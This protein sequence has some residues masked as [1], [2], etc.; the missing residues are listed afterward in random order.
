VKSVPHNKK[1]KSYLF[2][3]IVTALFLSMVCVMLASPTVQFAILSL[4]QDAESFQL[5]SFIINLFTLLAA[6]VDVGT[7]II[8][9]IKRKD[10]FR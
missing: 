6:S 3:L 9:V 4:S 10:I 7:F 5:G 8:V 1:T 2:Q